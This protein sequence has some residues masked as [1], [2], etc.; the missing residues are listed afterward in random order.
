MA[1]QLFDHH[2]ALLA[3][4]QGDT[5]AL[6]SLY[7][8]EAP[9]MLALASIMLGDQ[10]LAQ[11]AVRDAFVL[12][13]KNAGSHDPQAG[14]ARAWM[15]SIMRY[16]I[17]QRL[18]QDGA[19]APAATQYSAPGAALPARGNPSPIAQRL[20]RLRDDQR[21]PILMAFYNGLSYRQIA[22]RLGASPKQLQDSV[23]SGLRALRESAS[24]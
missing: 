24:V 19:Q 22:A 23:R 17:L 16:R 15:Y 14:T 3:C 21:K 12:I 4:A 1:D 18:R 20:S 11:D 8:H 13:W 6:D 7:A 10:A 5:Q 9:G 2:A